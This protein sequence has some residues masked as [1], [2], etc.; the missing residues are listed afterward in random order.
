[1]SNQAI[2]NSEIGI[3]SM[4]NYIQEGFRLALTPECHDQTVDA[5]IGLVLEMLDVVDAAV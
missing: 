3:S 1:M 2:G 4:F 5:L